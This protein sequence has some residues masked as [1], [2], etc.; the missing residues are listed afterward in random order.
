M[1]ETGQFTP[2]QSEYPTVRRRTVGGLQVLLAAAGFGTLAIFGKV[3]E[4]VGL[5]TTTL[6][7]FRFGVGTALLW[8][9]LAAVGRV[10]RLRGRDLQIALALGLLYAVF[11]ALFFWGLLYVPASVAG[12]AFYTYPVY[13]YVISVTLLAEPLSGRKLAALALTLSGVAL[14]VGGDTAGVDLFGIALV[15]LA[16]VGY[17]CYIAGTRAA[18]SSIDADTLAGTAL[19]GTALAYL[20][21]GLGSGRLSVPAGPDQWLVV[22]GIA[23]VGT[24]LPIFLY[25]AGLDR[26]EASRASV[27]STAEP[28]VTVLLG[29]ALLGEALTPAVVAGGGLVLTGVLL[30]QTDGSTGSEPRVPQ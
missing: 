16:A 23:V 17:A 9:G 14:I 27:I 12:I 21:F 7:T 5:D 6:L 1:P 2:A 10:R 25:V 13:V 19:V 18:V 24:T 26:I 3:A 20:G 29:I 4:A 11:T 8:L 15:L 30:V 22:A 28:V